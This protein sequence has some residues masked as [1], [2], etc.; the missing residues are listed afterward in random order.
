MTPP[1]RRGR[2]ASLNS[3]S[4][5]PINTKEE[6][7]KGGLNVDHG[8]SVRNQVF[9]KHRETWFGLKE[10]ARAFVTLNKAPESSRWTRR[11][12][13]GGHVPRS[14]SAERRLPAAFRRPRSASR[15][16]A[17]PG[18][19]LQR[20]P[21]PAQ[22]SVPRRIPRPRSPRVLPPLPAA[23]E[24][25]VPRLRESPRR[26]V[27]DRCSAERGGSAGLETGSNQSEHRYESKP[28]VAPG[29]VS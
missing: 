21:G 8:R 26:R 19:G 7:K 11:I 17:L 3:R 23:Q 1:R 13:A 14:A 4:A 15:A 16:Q 25:P 2:C 6:K 5:P 10:S 9:V 12:S 28:A 18:A 24:V 20:G 27:L 29:S 22:G